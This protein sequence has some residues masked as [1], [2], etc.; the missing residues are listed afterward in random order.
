MVN[1]CDVETMRFLHED[2]SEAQVAIVGPPGLILEIGIQTGLIKL[3]KNGR[4]SVKV[5][6]VKG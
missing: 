4:F 2:G 6:I 1:S 3:D 5:E